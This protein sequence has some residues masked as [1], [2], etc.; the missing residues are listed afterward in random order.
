VKKRLTIG[1]VG[2]AMAAAMT[3]AA[4]GSYKRETANAENARAGD[5]II[6]SLISAGLYPIGDPARRG[7]YYVLHAYDR[8][9]HEVRVVVDAQL[10]DILSVAPATNGALLNYQRGP[11]IIHVPQA[12]ASVNDRDDEAPAPARR[13]VAP[14]VQK[15]DDEPPRP[16]AP[17]W[18]PRSEAPPQ[19]EQRRAVLSAVP[20]LAEGPTPVRPIPRINSKADTADKFS[21][22]RETRPNAPPPASANPDG[23]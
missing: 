4:A 20:P 5:E 17:R 15:Q 19:Q 22:P 12:E 7:P 16:R 9:G 18:Q 11:H 23:G 10:G 1:F 13:R 8:R 6:N 3:L 14:A 21:Q 2:A